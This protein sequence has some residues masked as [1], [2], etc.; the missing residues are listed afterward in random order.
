MLYYHRALPK[1]LS[2]VSHANLRALTA[3]ALSAYPSIIISMRVIG[4]GEGVQVHDLIAAVLL[5]VVFAIAVVVTGSEAHALF[6]K[7]AVELDERELAVR[8]EVQS[9]AYF[10]FTATVLIALVYA[11]FVSTETAWLPSS[12]EDWMALLWGAIL[13]AVLLPTTI[14]AWTQR[15]HRETNA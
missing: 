9:R 15:D 10:L 11:F 8:S 7:A 3:A 4:S 1:R 6:G 5:L 2:N 14:L 13:Y 12:R